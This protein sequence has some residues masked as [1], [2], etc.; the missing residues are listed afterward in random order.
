MGPS[1]L[2]PAKPASRVRPADTAWPTPVEL[3]AGRDGVAAFAAVK[4]DYCPMCGTAGA[5]KAPAARYRSAP[6]MRR[7]R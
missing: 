2:F 4:L 7:A 1:T 6:S 3:A 5:W